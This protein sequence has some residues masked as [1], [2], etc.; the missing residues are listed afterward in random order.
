MHLAY[1]THMDG[2]RTSPTDDRTLL[3]QGGDRHAWVEHVV[4][5][6][7]DA[8]YRFA[9]ARLG[10]DAEFGVSAEDAVADA[11]A[12]AYAIRAKVRTEQ[13][14]GSA[15]P[16]L[17][18]ILVRRCE[19]RRRGAWRERRRREAAAREV[20]AV[21]MR[22]APDP[23]TAAVAATSHAVLRRA[24]ATLRPKERQVLTLHAIGE[25]SLEEVALALGMPAATARSHLS[26]ARASL[27]N[28]PAV[29]ALH[30]DLR[31]AGDIR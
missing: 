15:L 9:R 24:L 13:V 6:H 29:V 10:P 18:A 19:S 26:R 23:A 2:T 8:M 27:V 20:D 11:V 31:T 12:D 1:V 28:H 25:L 21:G 22:A 30:S 17:L 4:G 3:E 14:P 7:L 16:W 5:R